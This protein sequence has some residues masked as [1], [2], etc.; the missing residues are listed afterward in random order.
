MLRLRAEVR[1]GKIFP[2]PVLTPTPAKM[3]DIEQLQLRPRRSDSTYRSGTYRIRLFFAC[4]WLVIFSDSNSLSLRG[5]FWAMFHH[6]FHVFSYFFT[7]AWL[8]FAPQFVF[9]FIPDMLLSLPNYEAVCSGFVFS[10]LF[11]DIFMRL[12]C[13]SCLFLIVRY[14]AEF[15]N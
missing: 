10:C 6:M 2:T 8:S 5:L 11:S 7:L 9:H 1:L 12:V 4:K 14:L 15:Q 3:I 13:R